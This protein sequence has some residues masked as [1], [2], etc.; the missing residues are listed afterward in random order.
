MAVMNLSD[1]LA[2]WETDAAIDPSELDAA[3]RNVPL[4]HAKW[5]RHYTTERLR[6]KKLDLEFKS[7]YLLRYEYWNGRLDEDTRKAQ[8]WDIQPLKV[9][10]PQLPTYLDAD[11]VLQELQKRKAVC[12]ETLRFLEDVIKQINGRGYH[13][14]NAIDF[15]KFKMGV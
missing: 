3:A 9:L 12:E 10:T 8:G 4:L 7:L 2:A 14:K 11:P 13:I 6:Y 15:L 5:W 1:Y